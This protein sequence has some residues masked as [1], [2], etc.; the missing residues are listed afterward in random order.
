ML[1]TCCWYVHVSVANKGVIDLQLYVDSDKHKIIQYFDW[2]S[3][4]FQSKLIEV[5][6][7]PNETTDTVALYVNS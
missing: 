7:T 6:N 3:G 4:G 2:M 5:Q 1:G